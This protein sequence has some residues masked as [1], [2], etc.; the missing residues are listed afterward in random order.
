MAVR[1][2]FDTVPVADSVASVTAVF[3][4]VGDLGERAI[5]Q[6]QFADT[7]VGVRHGLCQGAN[8]RLQSVCNREA[9]WIVRSAIDA[10]A[11]GQ[12]L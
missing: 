11:R 9:S 5:G 10:R 2:P 3:S 7:V 4:R 6:L 8:I 1:C 12:L